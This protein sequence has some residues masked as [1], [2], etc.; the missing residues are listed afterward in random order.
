MRWEAFPGTWTKKF[1]WFGGKS[2]VILGLEEA[3]LEK[4]EAVHSEG[5][6]AKKGKKS[7]IKPLSAFAGRCW[8]TLDDCSLGAQCPPSPSMLLQMAKFHSFLAE[9]YSIVHVNVCMYVYGGML[10][11]LGLTLWD[12]IDCSLMALLSMGF[13]RQ[14][15]WIGLP[16]PPPGDLS[17]TGTEPMFSVSPALYAD[18]LQLSQRVRHDWVTN[19]YIYSHINGIG[20]I[21]F[22]FFNVSI[23]LWY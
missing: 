3:D 18:S 20:S 21:I 17:N 10:V 1:R 11:E 15:Y 22:S 23:W 19:T 7:N 4:Q 6:G 8:G 13:S 9:Q 14:E 12:P 16:F 2:C 5:F